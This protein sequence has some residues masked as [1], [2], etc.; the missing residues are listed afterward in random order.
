ME[1]TLIGLFHEVEEIAEDAYIDEIRD[2]RDA[3]DSNIPF[4]KVVWGYLCHFFE[5]LCGT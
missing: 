5:H 2:I 4:Y 1:T 3:S